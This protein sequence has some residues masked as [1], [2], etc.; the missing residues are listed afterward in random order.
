MKSI[1]AKNNFGFYRVAAATPK[2]NIADIKFNTKQI[3]KYITEAENCNCTALTLP[4]L[5]LTGYTCADLFH[6]DLL[7]N[8]AYEALQEIAQQTAQFKVISIV[9]APIKIKQKLFNCAVIIH[10][11]EIKGI[12]PKIN[13]PNYREFYEKRWFDSGADIY[14]KINFP[15][16]KN[17]VLVSPYQIFS[18]D[19]NFKFGI[20]ICED[21]WSVIPPSSQLTL[22]G[23]TMIFNPSASNELVAKDEYRKNLISQ[24][25]G[26]CICG[27][28]YASSGV[29]ESTTDVVYG[30]RSLIAANGAIITKNHRFNQHGSIIFADIDCQRLLNSRNSESSFGISCSNN[31]SIHEFENIIFNQNRINMLNLKEY[32]D[33]LEFCYIPEKPFV[34]ND[35]DKRNQNCR[36][37]FNIQTSGLAKRINHTKAKKLIV[38]ISGGLDS[39]LA[40]LV[41][42]ETMKL[43]YR[44]V[45]DIVA[46]T[47]PGFGTTDRTY[48]NAVNLCKKLGVEMREINIKEA[49]LQHF[50]DIDHDV[51]IHDITYEN[52]QAR[53]RTKILMNLANKEQGILIG[54][55]DLSEI[56]LGWSTYNG[57]HM[58]MYAVNCSIPKTLIRYL[59]EWVA[60]L[61][62]VDIQN[63]LH[64]IIDTPVSPELLP[65]NADAD[66]NQKTEDIIGP[67]EL[68]DFFLY[69]FVKYGAEPKKLYFLAQHVFAGKY[70]NDRIVWTLKKFIWRFFSQQ[71]K[72]SCIPDGP[73]VGT[74]SLSPRGDWRMPSDCSYNLWI[75][76]VEEIE[77]QLD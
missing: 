62:N 64:D 75:N 40:L 52:V 27:Y 48:N 35:E 4:E 3:I 37:I 59:I 13:L 16:Q 31:L 61:E 2:L 22:N 76:E 47:M 56:A 12:V 63:I 9:G 70:T 74:I 51:N 65:N 8:K 18:I 36:E 57:D 60:E 23:A 6:S 41:C 30:G 21:M 66:I 71:F 26:R 44:N 54:T 1:V 45:N 32:A 11:G 72:R 14:E 42:V 39:T 77:R 24:Q 67:Y 17:D 68:H 29:H 20:E 55:G 50:S 19:N 73:K 33:K 28:V 15:I 7:I 5:S 43:L 25:S 10:A 34:P 53:E 69:H 38:G 58:S 49:C 46:I